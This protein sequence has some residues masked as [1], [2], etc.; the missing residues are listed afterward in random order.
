MDKT[1]GIY[2]HIPSAPPARLMGDFYL[3]RRPRQAH[4]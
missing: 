4:A 2:I 3:R 1:L